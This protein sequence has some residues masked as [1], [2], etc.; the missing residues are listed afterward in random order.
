MGRVEP[1]G[2]K[3]GDKTIRWVW[4]GADGRTPSQWGGVAAVTVR[5]LG[6]SKRKPT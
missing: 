2:D 5:M 1:S 6:A 4:K 3:A